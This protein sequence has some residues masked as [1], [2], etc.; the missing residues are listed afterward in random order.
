MLKSNKLF[1]FII[2]GMI[3]GW[4]AV[5]LVNST[6]EF[7]P[8]TIPQFS[9]DTVNTGKI[10]SVHFDDAT[11]ETHCY[12]VYNIKGKGECINLPGKG[13]VVINYDTIK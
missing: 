6:A 13:F 10:I 3:A 1:I 5:S 2:V 11:K 7:L 8:R 12:Y 9:Q 4:L